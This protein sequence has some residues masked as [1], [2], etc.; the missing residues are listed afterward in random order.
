MYYVRLRPCGDIDV[1][2]EVV[3]DHAALQ[4][5]PARAHGAEEEE[6]LEGGARLH[7]AEPFPLLVPVRNEVGPQVQPDLE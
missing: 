7:E 2:G 4:G 1:H 3:H 5:L 6:L